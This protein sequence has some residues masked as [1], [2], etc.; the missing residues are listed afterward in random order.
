MPDIVLCVADSFGR[1]PAVFGWTIFL[2]TS[3]CDVSP[4]HHHLGE[5]FQGFPVTIFS[6]RSFK[7][8]PTT[9]R[10][11]DR[12]KT[13]RFSNPMMYSSLLFF[14]FFVFSF[15]L[16]ENVSRQ[17][18]TTTCSP[19]LEANKS[20]KSGW[21]PSCPSRPSERGETKEDANARPQDTADILDQRLFRAWRADP[22]KNGGA[23]RDLTSAKLCTNSIA[24]SLHLP[25]VST[26]TTTSWHRSLVRSSWYFRSV[27]PCCSG[28][29]PIRVCCVRACTSASSQRAPQRMSTASCSVVQWK[30]GRQNSIARSSLAGTQAFV[31]RSLALGLTVAPASRHTLANVRSG[32]A[33]RTRSRPDLGHAALCLPN[34]CFR[35]RNWPR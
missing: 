11:T 9:F 28:D 13:A 26:A 23:S 30:T 31:S 2:H 8:L 32:P 15:F 20:D 29:R 5:G 10:C 25:P 35:I 1:C 3:S 4:S 14:F 7:R 12:A 16:Y 33:A 19:Q 27:A 21:C 6:D 18:S 34:T 17:S 22:R 24:S